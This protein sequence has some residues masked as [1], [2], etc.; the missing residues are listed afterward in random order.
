MQAKGMTHLSYSNWPCKYR[1]GNMGLG[2]SMHGTQTSPGL[3]VPAYTVGGSCL[4]ATR[5]AITA[6]LLLWAL[7]LASVDSPIAHS[8]HMLA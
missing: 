6:G 2:F 8:M 3:L 1:L 5:C 7:Y 4:L